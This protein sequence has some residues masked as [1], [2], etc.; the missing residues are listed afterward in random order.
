[1]YDRSFWLDQRTFDEAMNEVV[2][3][4]PALIIDT[5]DAVDQDPCFHPARVEQFFES[6]YELVTTVHYA[7]IY[8]L[9]SAN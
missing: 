6:D 4:K 1:M 7:K 3:A 5:M 8:R 9:K 2:K